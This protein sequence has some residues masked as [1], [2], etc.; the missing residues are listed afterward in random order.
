MKKRATTPTGII[1]IL[2]SALLTSI[3]QF[4]WKTA[5][6][7]NG[8]MKIIFSL[9]GF[10]LFFGT[11]FLMVLSYRFGEVSVLQPILSIGF[12]FSLVLGKVFFHEVQTPFKYAGVA[13]ILAGVFFLAHSRSEMESDA[14][15]VSAI[16]AK[17]DPQD[18]SEEK[19]K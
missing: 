9:A 6:L 3:G 10:A 13:L 8:Y 15:L 16:D 17:V 1:L 5:A 14:D 19:E 12:V 11:G 4:L 7:S 2:I 18:L